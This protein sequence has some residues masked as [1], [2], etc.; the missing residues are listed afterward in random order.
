MDQENQV[1]AQALERE[2]KI[3]QWRR[4]RRFTICFLVTSLVL[5][6]L[7]CF[8]P[9][10]VNTFLISQAKTSAQLTQKNEKDW[11]GIPGS[12][13]I[14]IYWKQYMYNC[15]NAWEVTYKNAKPEFMEFGPYIYR[16]TD[17]YSD[18]VYQDLDNTI[19]GESLPSVKM[20]FSQSVQYD[21]SEEMAD[22]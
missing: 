20:S 18:L 7:C 22:N 5:I 12:N 6:V 21:D 1:R 4:R 10:T 13:D 19:S 16:E 2:E 15:T 17:T 9:V 14:G 8:T 11:R 3:K